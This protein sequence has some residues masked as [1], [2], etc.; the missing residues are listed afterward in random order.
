MHIKL[1]LNKFEKIEF[2]L[3]LVYYYKFEF[4]NSPSSLFYHE[5]CTKFK[6]GF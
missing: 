6:V 4:S 1:D 5:R 3:M 2:I